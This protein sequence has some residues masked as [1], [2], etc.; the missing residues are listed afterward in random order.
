[1]PPAEN[2]KS[3]RSWVK[4]ALIAVKLLISFGLLYFLISSANINFDE[5]RDTLA[6]T[7]PLYVFLAFLTPYLGFYMTSLRWK[8]L[9]EVQGAK[10]RQPILFKSCMVAVFFNQIMPSTIGGDVIRMYDSWKAG[11]TRAVSISTIVVDRVLGLFALAIFAVLGLFFVQGDFSEAQYVPLAVIAVAMGLGGFIALVFSPF[12]VMV[13]LARAIYT[14]LPGPFGK[15]FGK[16]D[17]AVEPF[18]GRHGSLIRALVI[19]LLLQ[20]NVVLLHYLLSLAIGIE[21]GFFDYFYVVPVALFVMLIPI[22]I[23]G[24]GV[25]E[26]MFVFLLGTMGVAKADALV[27]SLLVFA[28][29]LVHGLI[30]G[31][32]LASRGISPSKLAKDASTPATGTAA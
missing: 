14:K 5:L 25:R 7:D 17:K 24:I 10:I 28:V 30:G 27:L 8:G 31:L 2:V 15:F 12:R 19:S 13:N 16:V 32:V 9:L 23:N 20:L 21:L 4:P 22:S 29:F 18:R 6:K 3:K 11:A 1:M 26:S